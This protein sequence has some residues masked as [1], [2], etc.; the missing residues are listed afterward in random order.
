MSVQIGNDFMV[1]GGAVGYGSCSITIDGKTFVGG[2]H[3]GPILLTPNGGK[4]SLENGLYLNYSDSTGRVAIGT[5]I[6]IGRKTYTVK[7]GKIAVE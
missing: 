4:L 5:M 3:T 2:K 7:D 1:L 6:C